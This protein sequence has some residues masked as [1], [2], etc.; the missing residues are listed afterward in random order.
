MILTAIHSLVEPEALR[1]DVILALALSDVINRTLAGDFSGG[2]IHSMSR[3][4]EHVNCRCIP[5]DERG[6]GNDGNEG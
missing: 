5:M 3:P 1:G 6:A 4:T 2:P